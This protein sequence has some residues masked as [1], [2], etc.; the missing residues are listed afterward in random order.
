MRIVVTSTRFAIEAPRS[1]SIPGRLRGSAPAPRAWFYKHENP[2]GALVFYVADGY[3]VFSRENDVI[4]AIFFDLG[5][6]LGVPVLSVDHRLER[7]EPFQFAQPVL[8]E[9]RE[10][11]MRLGV[12]SN[13]GEEPG[14]RMNE[15]LGE[16]ALL[17]FFEPTLLVYSKD[18]GLKKD[19]PKIFQHAAKAAGLAETPEHCLFVGEDATERGHALTAGWRVCPHPLLVGE[20][21]AGEELRYARIQAPA[22]R[23]RQSWVGALGRLPLVPLHVDGA[24]GSVVYV[25]TSQR[26]AADLMNAQFHVAM[27]GEP[28]GPLRTELYLLRDDQAKAT[29]WMDTQGEAQKLFA[30]ADTARTVLESGGGKILVALPPEVSL[31]SIHFENAQ[32]GHTLRLMADPHLLDLPAPGV[33]PLERPAAAFAGPLVSDEEAAVWST[34]AADKIQDRVERF[35]GQRPLQAAGTELISSRHVAHADNAAAVAALARELGEISPDRLNVRLHQFSHQSL[36]LHNVVAELAGQ[37]PELVLVSAHLD[38]IAMPGNPVNNPAPGADDDMSG[39]AGVL[40]IAECITA[41]SAAHGA[42]ERTVQFVLFND[43][44]NGLVGSR[45]YARQLRAAG[46]QIAGVFQMDMIGFNQADPRTWEIHVGFAASPETEARSMPLAE[47][48]KR[49]VPHVSPSL[50][51]PQIFGPGEEDPA[52]ERS[53]HASF[54]AHGYPACITSEDFFVGP[55][56][57]AS[58]PEGNPNYHKREDTFIDAVYTADI[59]RSVGAAAWA[60]ATGR[61]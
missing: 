35:T 17:G 39:V 33:T 43:E 38:S 4:S 36:T 42:P 27:L 40:A 7:F 9:L 61:L 60:I 19:S 28:D 47:L 57:D 20:V 46:A 1:R 29:G 26:T 55:G 45:A 52:D 56:L 2:F 49:V 34:L 5:D 51:E 16:C 21:L 32:H 58:E 6:T 3:Q 8:K 22:G 15:V 23:E 25:I 30:K 18:A 12:I 10:R 14:A 50:P 54:Q 59:A 44:E 48:I 24:G 41:L 53:D 11:A 13:T 31:S 37:S